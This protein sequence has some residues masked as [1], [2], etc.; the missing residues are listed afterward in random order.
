MCFR[1]TGDQRQMSRLFRQMQESDAERFC[2][3]SA[4]PFCML[5]RMQL[6]VVKDEAAGKI[7]S[8]FQVPP[9]FALQRLKQIIFKNYRDENL[10]KSL[11]S[12]EEFTT[13]ILKPSELLQQSN[14]ADD[15]SLIISHIHKKC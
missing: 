15:S 13:T 4:I 9:E 2:L 7:A 6:P 14:R 11:S 1:H 5:E 10:K 12:D 3:Y 8:V